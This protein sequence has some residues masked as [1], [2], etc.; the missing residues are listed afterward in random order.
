MIINLSR[1]GKNG[2]GMWQYS[3]KF[4]DA[5]SQLNLLSGIICNQGHAKLLQQYGVELILVPDWIGNSSQISRLRPLLWICY[6]AWLS[7]R[8]ILRKNKKSIVSTTHHA[9][10]FIKNQIITVHDLR[11]YYHPDSKLQ[12]FYFHYML[13]RAL[14]KCSSVLTVS[15]TVR[16]KISECYGY[17]KERTFV[18]YN[19]VDTSDFTPCKVKKKYLLAVGASWKHKNIDSFLRVSDLWKD[20]FKLVIVSGKTSYANTLKAYVVE[21]N[22]VDSVEFLHDVPYKDLVNLYRESSGLIYPSLDEGFGIPPIEALSCRTPV[23]V[24]DIDVFH[25]VLGDVAIYVNPDE[26]ASWDNALA[27]LTSDE[28]WQLSARQCVEKYSLQNMKMMISSWVNK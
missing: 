27:K 11:P 15:Y 12:A 14:K 20:K 5:L 21:Q 9:L 1:I 2:T 13:P 10:P 19:A 28:L 25:E 23:I 3:I 22:M 16:N 24:S 17:P 26:V 8:L 18:I 7:L 4:L 6:S